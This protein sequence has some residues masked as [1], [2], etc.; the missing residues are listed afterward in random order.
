MIS[1]EEQQAIRS[2]V[3]EAATAFYGATARG[4]TQGTA[5]LFLTQ[6][7]LDCKLDEAARVADRVRQEYEECSE[8]QRLLYDPLLLLLR[9][10][11]WQ[12]CLGDRRLPDEDWRADTSVRPRAR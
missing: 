4:E 1:L 9:R 12:Q 6:V 10:V 3:L 2:L 8:E 5:L 7:L 11:C